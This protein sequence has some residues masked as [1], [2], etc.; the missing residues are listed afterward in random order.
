MILIAV[1]VADEDEVCGL[2]NQA[3][4]TF[5]REISAGF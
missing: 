5:R 1:N 4:S 2:A 3:A